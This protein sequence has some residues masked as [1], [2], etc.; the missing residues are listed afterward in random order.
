MRLV[1]VL[2]MVMV[3]GCGNRV[4]VQNPVQPL[5]T[6]TSEVEESAV[7]TPTPTVS[8][9]PTKSP[10]AVPTV[11]VSN[12]DMVPV[13]F[14]WLEGDVTFPYVDGVAKG[15]V[16][17]TSV[18]VK[19]Q[20][21]KVRSDMFSYFRALKCDLNTEKTE[22]S[23]VRLASDNCVAVLAGVIERYL[24]IVITEN[25]DFPSVEVV[26]SSSGDMACKSTYP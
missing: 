7:S 11:V 6:P 10:T 25:R 23:F 24:P 16:L 18:P 12:F 2:V 1:K 3:V 8:P 19:T 20:V 13:T 4:I 17:P 26:R 9:K 22:C 5:Q 21:V 14:K 15:G